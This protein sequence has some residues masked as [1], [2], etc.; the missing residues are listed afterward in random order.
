MPLLSPQ[1]FAKCWSLSAVKMLLQLLFL[2][3]L[4]QS[5]AHSR[6]VFSLRGKNQGDDGDGGGGGWFGGPQLVVVMAWLGHHEL[7][8]VTAQFGHYQLAVVTA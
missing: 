2:T 8:I 3:D 5:A 6:R 7:A 4:V 1:W